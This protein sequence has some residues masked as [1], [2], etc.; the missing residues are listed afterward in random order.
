MEKI[1]VLIPCYNEK[2]TIKKVV[3]DFRTALPEAT[4]YV[5]DNRSSDGSKQIARQA[6]AIVKTVH[7]RGK[8]NVLVHMLK[9][10]EAECYLIVDADDTYPAEAAKRMVQCLKHAD[11][12]LGDRLTTTYFQENSRLFHSTGNRMVRFLVNQLFNASYTDVMTGY[13]VISKGFADFLRNHLQSKE[14]EIETEICIWAA[15]QGKTVKS[16]PIRYKDRPKGSYSKLHTIRDGWKILKT[17]LRYY[18]RYRKEDSY[19]Y[20][21]NIGKNLSK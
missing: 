2:T 12:V 1:A 15:V 14:F 16:I 4:V 6:G 8:G 18:I 5:Y 10:I 20:E 3:T 7:A 17:I 13:R 21:K 19:G 11:M 9:D